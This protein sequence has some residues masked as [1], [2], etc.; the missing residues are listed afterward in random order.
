MISHAVMEGRSCNS[1]P[2]FLLASMSVVDIASWRF[3]PGLSALD[4]R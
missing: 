3:G 2:W 4:I 1:L